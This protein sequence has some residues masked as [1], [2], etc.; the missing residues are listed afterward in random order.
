LPVSIDSL[1]DRS[2]AAV[3]TQQGAEPAKA[4]AILMFG[5]QGF[6]GVVDDRRLSAVALQVNA[7]DL[8]D[9]VAL[10]V[11]SDV[12][13]QSEAARLFATVA[14]GLDAAGVDPEA[15]ERLCQMIVNGLLVSP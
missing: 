2:A 14:G 15:M 8:T 9:Q 3:A 6:R 7:A 12:A 5:G 4:F 10:K 11:V 1:K 13:R